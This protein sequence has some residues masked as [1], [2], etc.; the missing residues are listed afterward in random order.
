MSYEDKR[1][2]C[3]D[4][5]LAFV[6]SA[7]AQGLSDELGHGAPIRCRACR[8]SLETR[9]RDANTLEYR[10]DPFG[11]ATLTVAPLARAWRN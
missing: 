6:F 11:L 8:Q 4:C 7:E 3:P 1:L 5:R 9:R 10:P 2:T